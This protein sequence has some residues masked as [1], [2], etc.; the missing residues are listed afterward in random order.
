MEGFSESV[1][2][3][4]TASMIWIGMPVSDETSYYE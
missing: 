4:I 1:A 2:V 3:G